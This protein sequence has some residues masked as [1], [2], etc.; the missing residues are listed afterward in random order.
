M[1]GLLSQAHRNISTEEKNAERA[2][3]GATHWKALRIFPFHGIRACIRSDLCQ[4]SKPPATSHAVLV[5]ALV[6]RIDL[7]EVSRGHCHRHGTYRTRRLTTT[8]WSR[9]RMPS[10]G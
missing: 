2:R 6:T 10:S 4:C 1:I 5:C 8:V 7:P 9:A 3:E